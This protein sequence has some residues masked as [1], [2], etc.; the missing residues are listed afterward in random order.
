MPAAA[1]KVD[2]SVQ[3]GGLTFANPFILPSAQ[4]ARTGK[5]I[6][7]AFQ[8]GWAGA[9]TQTIV[10]DPALLTNV[11]P[12]LVSHRVGQD[13][14]GIVNIEVTSQRSIDEWTIDIRE[15]KQEFPEK[16]LVASIAADSMTGWRRLALA[17][18][19]AG[20][21]GLELNVSIPHALIERG[22]GAA[23]GVD[24]VRA[25][26]VTQWVK[27]VFD[28]PIWV[29]LTPDAVD[30]ADVGRAAVAAGAAALTVANNPR[31]I[32]G[33]DIE[34][35]VP[36]PS[37]DGQTAFGGYAGSSVKPIIMRSVAE[38]AAALPRT[39]VLA[40][41][42]T[43]TWEDA[44]ESLLFGASLVQVYT[45]VLSQGYGLIAELTAGLLDYMERHRFGSLGEFRGLALS[46]LRAH[47][48]LSRNYSVVAVNDAGRCVR[49][50]VCSAACRDAG[51]Q[52][53]EWRVGELPHIDSAACVGC[54][55]CA[56][57]CPPESLDMR[58]RAAQ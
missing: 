21:S 16:P 34:G 54:G 9:V 23:I 28:G 22:G 24:P 52:A 41:G 55:L 11:T 8:L 4:T 43:T 15:L 31:A 39:P 37:V 53:I 47:S 29:K 51:Y 27:D 48:S 57:L 5:M 33:F 40:C 38:V 14:I 42:T 19:A 18:G 46:T 50:G 49:C 32:G 20:V 10:P 44:V 25:G 30:I 12:R 2:I 36:R 6:R 58:P 7:R 26:L 45:P 56:A 1:H 35:L 17:C 13:V 3:V